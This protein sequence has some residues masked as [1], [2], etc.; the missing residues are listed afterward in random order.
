MDKSFGAAANAS[1]A[2]VDDLNNNA[3]ALEK[4]S[5]EGREAVRKRIAG[6][7]KTNQNPR[8]DMLSAMRAS[9]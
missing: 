3:E 1:A 9:G 7:Q 8:G 2:S 6:K 4:G 5:K